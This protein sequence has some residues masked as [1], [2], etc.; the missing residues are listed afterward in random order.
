MDRV[1]GTEDEPGALMPSPPLAGGRASVLCVHLLA[2]AAAEGGGEAALLVRD[3]DG[4]RILG[5]E[6]STIAYEGAACLMDG[7]AVDACTVRLLPVRTGIVEV[8]LCVRHNAPALDHVRALCALQVDELLREHAAFRSSGENGIVERM[9]L[10]MQRMADTAEVAF[11]RCD[12]ATRMVTGDARFA[13]IWGLAPERLAVGVPISEL[14]ASLHPDDRIIYGG[15]LE[16][17]LRNE[18]FYEL[19]FRILVHFQPPQSASHVSDLQTRTP[20]YTP[21]RPLVRHVLLRGWRED[22]KRPERRRS[23]GLA[24]DV[25]SASTTAEALRSSESFTR[26]LLSNLPDCIHILDCAGCIRFVN[27]GGIRSMEMDTPITMHGRPWIDLWR[28]QPRRRA[29]QALQTALGGETARFQGYAM[30]MR[31]QRRFWDVVVSPVFGEDGDIQRLLAIGR[32]LTEANQSSERLQLALDAGAIA[33]TWMWD[34]STSCMTGDARLAQTLGLDPDR[35]REGVMPNVI[36]DSV[37]PRDRFS[38]VQAVTAATRRGGRCRFEFRVETAAGSH[39]FEGNGRCDLGDEGRVA[40]FPGIVFDIDRS[41]RQAL[42]QAALVE[43]GDQLRALEDT[44]MMEEV[45]ARI[46]CRELDASGAGYG[47]VN[48]D[49]TG[50]TV[51]GVSEEGRPLPGV[52]MFEDY[53]EFR[54]L[55]ARGESVAISDVRTD[56]L[57]AGCEARYEAEGIVAFLSVPIFKFGRFVGLM[58]VCHETPHPWTEE[59]IVFTRAVADRTHVSM[60]QARTQQQIRD[61]NVMLEERILQRTRE[62]DRLW[63]IAKD[64]FVIIDRLGYYVAVS[65]SWEET[66]GYRVDELAG[67]RLDALCHPE[68]KQIVRDTFARLLEGTPW[69]TAGLDV[70]MRRSD[71]AWRTYNWSYNDEGDEIYAVG[72]DLTERNELEEQLRQAQKMEAVGQLTGGLAHDFNN[73]LAGIGGGLELL[74]LRIT[75]GRTEGLGR[76][77]AASQEA[78]RRAASLTHRL[79]AFSRRQTLDPTPTDVNLLVGGLESLLRGTV[80]PGIEL[81]SVLQPDLWLTRVDANQ[82]ENAILNLCI[83]ARDAMH[84]HG[85]T[86]RL[87]TANHVLT[88][89]NASDMSIQAGDYVILTVEDEGCGMLPEVVQ[90]AFDPFFTTKPIGEGT[91]L[92]LS[93]IYGF[94]QQSGGQVEIR[95]TPGEGTVVSLWLRRYQGEGTFRPEPAALPASSEGALLEGQRV[96]VVD[97]EDAVRMVVADMVTDLGGTVLAASDGPSALARAIE[98]APPTLLISDIG[99]PGGMNGRELGEALLQKWPTLKVLF[100]TGYAE[101]SILG[102][103]PLGP[104][105]ALL[106]KP[107]TVAA[108]SRKLALLLKDG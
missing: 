82:L 70:R 103:Q 59:E 95:S 7:Q 104:G 97:D 73:L 58:F 80:G 10:R 42:R 23:V 6:S 66:Q 48:D 102:D 32:D 100:I 49:G 19:R 39:W 46:I 65:P 68:D 79:L 13:R 106:V 63:N 99:M 77:I 86:L 29:A 38:V 101:Q 61:L 74:G 17:E 11:Y 44:G 2:L 84:G 75:Q 45:A 62:R 69:P 4:V 18:G 36:Y 90:R 53:G 5:G 88:V 37:D 72:R 47:L 52:R 25:S 108:F 3:A 35:L 85:T 12:F 16:E 24:M 64:L 14:V 20:S 41:K 89:E 33:G 31:G 91:G 92:G 98:G 67:L 15:S 34:D 9:Q 1:E 96:L 30:T 60:R 21:R 40:R 51:G 8:W 78:V 71:G 93:M 107:F 76:Y 105:C 55:L 28:G 57:T 87:A 22:E 43:L 81:V 56:P 27:E 94:A 54:T 83:N 50:M 26:L